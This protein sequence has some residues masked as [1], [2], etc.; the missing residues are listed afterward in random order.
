[1]TRLLRE[2]P[3]VVLLGARQVGKTTL[4][5][6]VAATFRASHFFDAES[7]ADHALL[8]EPELA[9]RD[10]RG[11]IVVDEVQLVPDVLRSVRVLAD[12][13][14]KPARFLLLGSASP[15]L[16]QK[17]AETLAGRAAFHEI[18]GFDIEEVGNLERLWFRG[19]FPRSYLAR[20]VR[21]SDEWRHDFIRTFLERDVPRLGIGVA[22]RTLERFWAMLA[23]YHGQILNAS[24]L[25]RSF[26][27]A[28]T[29]VR[30]YLDL[31]VGT[32]VVT[33]LRPWGENL[34]KRIVKSP[35]VYITD[36]GLLHALLDVPTPAALERHPK[37]GASWEGFVL[38][39]VLRTLRAR[40]SERFFWAVHSGPELDLLVVSGDRRYGFEFKRTDSPRIT[41]SMKGALELL[42][43]DRLDV[44]HAGRQTFDLGPK[45]RALAA[46]EI[47]SR[48]A[49][50]RKD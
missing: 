9:F 11:L 5:H 22:P 24:E 21:A 1:M 33:E 43:L 30:S 41:S 35:K 37:L 48:L 36:S 4:A 20:N 3:V 31:L 8:A 14:R 50:L 15:E 18:G 6:D 27:V 45:V 17:T 19:G 44:V 10:K 28:H 38:G 32:F 16:A 42:S 40:S 12:R 26:A 49:P 29:T 23:H 47:T 34:G 46:A 25:G 2:H 13:P 7:R 39:Q